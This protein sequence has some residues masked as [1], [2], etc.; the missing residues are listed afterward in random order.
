MRVAVLFIVALV[1]FPFPAAGLGP[2]TSLSAASASFIGEDSLDYAGWSVASGGDV[3]N[4]GFE[5]I[6][7]GADNDEEGG[8]GAG[9]TY[10][11]L[12][13]AGS[14]AMDTSPEE[15]ATASFL[16]ESAGDGAGRSVAFAG[17][18]ND[19][20]F[21]DIL[22]GANYRAGS[23]GETYLILGKAG[24]WAMNTSLAAADASFAGEAAGDWSGVWVSSAG[25]VNDDG[26][27]DILI[28]AYLNGEA[29]TNAG[30]TYLVLGKASGWAMDT[31]LANVDASFLGETSGDG[32]GKAAACAGDV[33][34]DGFDDILIGATGR[35]SSR[36]ETYLILGKASGWATDTSLASAD[37]S[38]VGETTR[39]ASGTA[40]ASAG[41]L[42]GDGFDDILIGADEN[43]DGGDRAGKAYLVLGR[44]SGWS[45]DTPLSGADASFLGE[46]AGDH[47]GGA[48]ASAGDV[49]GDGL[50]EIL[51][52]AT[53]RNQW[54]GEAYLIRGRETGWALDTNLVAADASFVGEDAYDYAGFVLGSGDVNGDGYSD[55]LISAAYD[56]DGGSYA[57][58]TYLILAPA[59]CGDGL[60]NDG[61]GFTDF[62]GG[63][64]GCADAADLS[65][66]SPLLAC[67]DGADNDSDGRVDFDPVT[68]ANPGDQYTPPSGSGDPGCK[69]PTW[70]TEN[71]QCQD[72]INNDP[73]QDP[74]PGL[75]DFDGGLSA[76]GYVASDPDPQCVGLAWKN[77]EKTA[78]GLGGFELALILPGLMWLHRRRRWLN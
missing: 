4:D 43:D 59:D 9:Q 64:P 31:S 12:G 51:I 39:E 30:Q 15:A 10:L 17:D 65:E 6:L 14:W 2:D 41:D 69:D 53:W 27:D 45:M 75:I 71:P 63:D 8:S 55:L 49:D 21:D 28:G 56:S 62:V 34:G 78:C 60:D 61:D 58:Q 22:I 47:A 37:A 20:G 46:D 57:G 26:F 48:V 74:D 70:S 72:G 1:A 5:D 3:N 25:D 67:D 54:Q 11:I 66:R 19:D 36:G 18:V 29:G 33:N 24:G 40:V 52:G 42:D 77:N 7:I 16:G 35:L 44:A 68:F 76:L 50:D 38:F 23:S 32:S 13:K 73:G